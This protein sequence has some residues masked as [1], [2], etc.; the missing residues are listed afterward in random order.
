M[1]LKVLM[2]S[3]TDGGYSVNIPA[4]PGCHSQGDSFEE[5]IFNIREAAELWIDVQVDHHTAAAENL[6]LT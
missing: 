5:A 3:E 2:Q 4:M 1:K 6:K